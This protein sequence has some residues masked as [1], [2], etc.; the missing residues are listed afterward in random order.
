M[1]SLLLLE[2]DDQ[3]GATF[4]GP[5]KVFLLLSEGVSQL[6]NLRR[7]ATDLAQS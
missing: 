7:Q 6:G 1:Y 4:G 2:L 3:G 5:L